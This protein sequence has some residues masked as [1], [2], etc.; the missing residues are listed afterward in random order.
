MQQYDLYN[1]TEMSIGT[2]VI[3]DLDMDGNLEMISTT[4][5]GYSSTTDYWTVTRM[6]LNTTTPDHLSWAAYLGTNYDG[7]FESD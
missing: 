3:V 7:V 5:T 1:R 2:P 6:N 4:T